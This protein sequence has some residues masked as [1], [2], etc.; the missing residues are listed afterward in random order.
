VKRIVALLSFG[1]AIL[2]SCSSADFGDK[3]PVTVS[4]NT[5]AP[6]WD[7]GIGALVASKCDNCHAKALS[8]FVPGEIKDNPARY[9]VGFAETEDRFLGYGAISYARVFNDS[10]KP[11]PPNYGTPLSED[12]KTALKKYLED[13][14]VNKSEAGDARETFVTATCGSVAP[15]TLT[16]ASDILPVATAACLGCHSEAPNNSGK[17]LLNS[18]A[19]WKLH[20][21]DLIWAMASS[22]ATLK[23]P[24]GRGTDY[25]APGQPGETFLKYLCSSSEIL[26]DGF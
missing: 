1:I 8:A 13:N 15:S 21:R 14:V 3:S 17:V 4:V 6:T 19:D 10:A 23:M 26:T 18:A 16:F 25:T 24:I 9:A 5:A 20:R 11:M 2:I 12:E 7:N 22:D